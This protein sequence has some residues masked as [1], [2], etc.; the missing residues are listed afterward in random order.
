M[1]QKDTPADNLEALQ[2]EVQELSSQCPLNSKYSEIMQIL[3]A[4]VV[5]HAA[6]TSV[7][8][9]NPAAQTILG[10]S[11]D[12]MLG[13]VAIDPHWYFFDAE[14]SR[15]PLDDYPV[16]KTISSC[17]AIRDMVMGVNRPDIDSV[18]WVLVNTEPLLSNGQVQEILVSFV[19]ITEVKQ[20]SEAL[21]NSQ[22]SIQNIIDHTPLGV[23]VT[24]E[25]GY[26]ESVNE[27][28]C[29]FYGYSES[30]L[31]GKHFTIVVP[32]EQKQLLSDLHDE[33]IEGG[34]EIRGEWDVM[35]RSGEIKTIL[36]D[37]AHIRDVGGRPKKVTFVMNITNEKE[38]QRQLEEKNRLLEEMT[39]TDPLTG[40]ANRRH[41]F[42]VLEA[43][44]ERAKRYTQKLSIAMLDIDYFKKVNDTYGHQTGDEV[45][46]AVAETV[47][48]AI[49]E[50]DV[51]GRYG[52][53]EFLLLMPNTDETGSL[54]LVKR[55]RMDVE[56]LSVGEKKIKVTVS[57]GVATYSGEDVLKFVETADNRLYAGKQAGRNQVVS[58]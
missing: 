27:A 47:R 23:C 51:V 4:G 8:Y 58:S 31:L 30:E 55:I 45:L 53:E 12:Q 24:D 54:Q 11:E 18:A 28:Y 9:C 19:D 14:G 17:Q 42:E 46:K 49:R 32:D 29:E 40:V 41:L 25:K 34:A 56:A 16:N 3:H 26:F 1:P 39:R 37:A 57:C 36:A 44:L 22:V 35:T 7:T 10:L 6:D 13:K 5:I 50:V 48:N 21:R 38:F 52:G 43:E 20:T 33:F 2:R 15:M